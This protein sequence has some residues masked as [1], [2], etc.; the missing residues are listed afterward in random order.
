MHLQGLW[1]GAS[2]PFRCV[3]WPNATGNATACLP[4]CLSLPALLCSFLSEFRFLC[5]GR[6]RRALLGDP[7]GARFA[8]CRGAVLVCLFWCETGIAVKTRSLILQ[9]EGEKLP[10]SALVFYGYFTRLPVGLFTRN[11]KDYHL[12]LLFLN[13]EAS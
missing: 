1:V 10:K 4:A 12:Y 9:C 8:V 7:D 6:R 11:R 2:V 3:P 5:G 13:V